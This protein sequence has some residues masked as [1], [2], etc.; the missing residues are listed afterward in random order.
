MPPP[1][2]Q[3]NAATLADQAYRALHAA[4]VSGEIP[5]GT[6]VT[7]RGLAEM[8]NVSVTPVREAIRRLE[9]DRLILRTGPRSAHVAQL[10]E[11]DRGEVVLI[12]SSLRALAARLAAERASEAQLTAMTALLDETDALLSGTDTVDEDV[13]LTV[14]DR[15]RTFHRMVD[16]AAGSAVLM[17]LLGQ[18]QAFDAADRARLLREQRRR[19]QPGP[20]RRYDEHRQILQA[21]VDR[22]ADRAEHLVLRHSRSAATELVATDQD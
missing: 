10:G 17:H 2:P 11:S 13:W 12:E 18:V 20:S 21:L 7:E 16:E 5:G 22:D 9:Q 6:R 15:L 3:L 1:L 14:L 19:G 8:L 4:V